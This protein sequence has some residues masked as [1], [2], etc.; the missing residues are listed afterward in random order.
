LSSLAQP[1]LEPASEDIE[2]DA[3]LHAWPELTLGKSE[4]EK[5]LENQECQ[6]CLLVV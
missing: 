5:T 2:A 1:G 4:K 6:R 3:F